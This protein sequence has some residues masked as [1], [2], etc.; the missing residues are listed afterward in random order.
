MRTDDGREY[1]S[2]V[3]VSNA[4]A[5]DTFHTM[6]E[7]D[8]YLKDYLARMDQFNVSSFVVQFLKILPEESDET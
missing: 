5:Y 2:K 3:V 1:S 7:E 8:D 6:M 4:N